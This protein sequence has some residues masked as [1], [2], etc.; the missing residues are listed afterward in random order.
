[1]RVMHFSAFHLD[2][3]YVTIDLV[4]HVAALLV[5]E[6]FVGGDV[7]LVAIHIILHFLQL[8]SVECTS[9]IV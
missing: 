4:M 6:G 7:S 3:S 9:V 2:I 5:C 1:M 8:H